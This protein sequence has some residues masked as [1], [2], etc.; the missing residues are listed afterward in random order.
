MKYIVK[1]IKDI[2]KNILDDFYDDIYELKKNRINKN[3]YPSIYAE[4]LLAELLKEYNLKYRFLNFEE[5]EFG[6]PY[7]KD[8]D[9]YY[10]IS[11]SGDYVL[12]GIHNTPIGVD[13]QKIKDNYPNPKVISKDELKYNYID[14]FSLKE[15]YIKC[16]GSTM[17]HMKDV[18][19]NLDG[20][21]I[22][23]NQ[24]EYDFLKFKSI[25][26]YVISIC[27]KRK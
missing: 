18:T 7:I 8:H 20:K 23:S 19:F 11:H 22:T 12:V 3:N 5:N 24:K 25:P 15:S 9:I 6:K 16:I 14:I 10:S 2:N 27:T 1:N 17:N 26:G 13:I 4:Y 21:T